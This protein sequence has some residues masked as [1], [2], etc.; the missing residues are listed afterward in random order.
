MGK[1][2][3]SMGVIDG[4]DIITI[5]KLKAKKDKLFDEIEKY[6][7][8]VKIETRQ[9][10][11]SS[12]G[13]VFAIIKRGRIKGIYLFKIEVK[14]SS[15]NLRHIKTVYSDEVTNDVREKYDNH[16]LNI[17]K[18]YV[19]MKEYDKVTLEDKVVQIDPK[20]SKKERNLAMIGGLSIGFILGGLILN[21]FYL[22]IIWGITFAFIFRGLDIVITNKRGRKKKKNM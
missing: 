14:E 18:D 11:N 10:V 22:G 16:I 20:K 15:K 2:L 4:Y 19:F 21:D 12:S 9:I 8:K 3:E 6:D 13:M 5:G 17:V 1:L 7:S